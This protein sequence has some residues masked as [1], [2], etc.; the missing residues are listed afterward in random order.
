MRCNLLE[1]CPEASWPRT[2][3]K[4][5]FHPDVRQ[6]EIGEC[7]KTHYFCQQKSLS[8]LPF[9]RKCKKIGQFRYILQNQRV[10]LAFPHTAFFHIFN[11]TLRSESRFDCKVEASKNCPLYRFSLH[12]TLSSSPLPFRL[13]GLIAEGMQTFVPTLL[14][15]TQSFGIWIWLA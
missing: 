15:N 8:P 14:L 10:F 1:F 9:A 4:M 6:V 11:S 7:V 3:K 5:N 12:K 13:W 2:L